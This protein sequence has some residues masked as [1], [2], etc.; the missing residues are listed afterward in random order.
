MVDEFSSFARMPSAVLEPV[1]L[2]KTVQESVFLQKVGHTETEI[3]VDLPE[4]PVIAMID[5]RLMTQALTNLVKNALESIDSKRQTHEGEYPG[6]INVRLKAD[7]STIRLRVIDNGIGF[8]K[9][10][11]KPLV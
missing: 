6:E 8:P 2:G 11:R 4:K 3:K 7:A 9:E 10:Q 1:D 5:R